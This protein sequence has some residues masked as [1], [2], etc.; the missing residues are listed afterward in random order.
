MMC[1]RIQSYYEDGHFTG[2]ERLYS[3]CATLDEGIQKFISEYPEH[4]SCIVIAE[5]CDSVEECCREHFEMCKACGY[6]H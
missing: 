4:K 1:V 5:H 3:N 6:V 2:C